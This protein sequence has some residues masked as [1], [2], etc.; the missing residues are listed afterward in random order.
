M[1]CPDI[2]PLDGEIHVFPTLETFLWYLGARVFYNATGYPKK[3][4]V[5]EVLRNILYPIEYSY[6]YTDV[7]GGYPTFSIAYLIYSTSHNTIRSSSKWLL[8]LPARSQHY[9]PTTF[10]TVVINICF[11]TT[12][13]IRRR[14]RVRKSP[15]PLASRRT[16]LY[17]YRDP[18]NRGHV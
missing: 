16:Y 8:T 3:Y 12:E 18:I 7:P 2:S 9:V 11:V 1:P 13:V 5:L 6:D 10:S 14:S 17:G 15:V 4:C